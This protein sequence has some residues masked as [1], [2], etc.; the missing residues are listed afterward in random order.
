MS[1]TQ[2]VVSIV[3]RVKNGALLS[4]GTIRI[5]RARA[6]HPHISSPYEGENDDGK[7]TKSYGC[8]GLLPK[9]ENRELK[10]LIVGEVNRLLKENRLEKM[11]ADRKFIK[12]GDLAAKDE[13]EGMW[14]VSSRENK[15]PRIRGRALDPKTGKPRRLTPEQAEGVFYGGCYV[16]LLIRPWFQNH[17]KYGKR[18][19]AN[20]VGIQ[21]IE[22]GEPFGESRISDDAIDDSFEGESPSDS[23]GWD[24]DD[25]L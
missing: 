8:V 13:Q 6:S 15:P 9:K 20:L 22:D 2:E 10:D 14:V 19:N 16:S 23:G 1:E 12:D 3:K 25:D 5:D 24:D 7:A 18:I 11:A 21:F 17:R 4:N